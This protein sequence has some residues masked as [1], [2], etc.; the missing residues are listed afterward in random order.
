M[1]TVKNYNNSNEITQT[2]LTYELDVISTDEAELP[3]Y[4]FSDLDGNNLGTIAK[5]E[6]GCTTK[7][8]KKYKVTFINAA[9]EEITRNIKIVT[10]TNQN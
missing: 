5:G 7:E 1:V 2:S 8:E 10:T 3:E 6:F 9:S 4:Y